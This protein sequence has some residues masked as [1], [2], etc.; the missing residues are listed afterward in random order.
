M[1]YFDNNATTMMPPEVVKEMVFW[2]N[3]GNP[4]SDYASGKRAHAMIDNARD[5]M[6]ELVG[7]DNTTHQ[8]IFVSGASEANAMILNNVLRARCVSSA[9]DVVPIP[10][11]VMSAIE[12]K[13]LMEHARDL[14]KKRVAVFTFIKPDAHGFIDPRDVARACTSKTRL[15][16]VMHANNETGAVN[17]VDAIGAIARRAKI[18][19]YSDCAQSFGK[20]PPHRACDALGVSFHKF[21][22]PPGIGAL[23]VAR[24][25]H[26]EPIIFGA[27]NEGVRGG[28]ENLP[29][30]G[31]GIMALRATMDHRADTNAR[32][33]G[34]KMW[35]CGEL[36]RRASTLM[37]SDYARGREFPPSACDTC[38]GIV[39][40]SENA[41][42]LPNTLLLSV[43]KTAPPYVCNTKMK[44]A[45]ADAGIVVSIGSACNTSSLKA[46]HVLHA[47]GADTRVRAG[48]L[49]VSLGPESTLEDAK[50]FVDVLMNIVGCTDRFCRV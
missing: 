16:C 7:V 44:H 8:V 35:I 9:F 12:H 25:M 11:V 18:P 28:T 30:I 31:A 1:I 2:C 40:I 21:G 23:I 6:M 4:S 26:I 13:G 36:A 37:F 17:D 14:E 49:R 38:D 29:G 41:N 3:R 5:Y 43:V 34:I 50:K 48:T 45:L 46:S 39:I 19:F 42:Y 15:I 47:I 33:K 32:M 10:H 24:A 27:Q 22:G 20:F